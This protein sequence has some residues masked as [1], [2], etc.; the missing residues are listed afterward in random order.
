VQ[1]KIAEFLSILTGKAP[2]ADE[3]GGAFGEGPRSPN[4]D[5]DGPQPWQDQGSFTPYG[6]GG[7][8]TAWGGAATTPYTNTPYG[9]S[10]QGGGWN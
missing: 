10:G 1:F 4:M 8:Q 7:N 6:N 2:T 3:T 9:Q 5:V